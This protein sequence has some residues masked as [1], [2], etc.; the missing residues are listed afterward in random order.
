MINEEERTEII[1]VHSTVEKMI[2]N[3]EQIDVDAES[4]LRM[5]DDKSNLMLYEDLHKYNDLNDVLGK[6]GSCIFLY[7]THRFEGH[8]SCIFKDSDNPDRLIFFDSYGL[9]MDEEL[10]FSEHNRRLHEGDIVPH[11]TALVNKSMYRVISNTY[12]YQK[13]GS[14]NSECGS[15][16][17]CRIIFR[18]LS[19]IQYR[20]FLTKN[21]HHD[22]DFWTVALTLLFR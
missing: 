2:M 11:L 20:K 13:D 10:Q 7:Q 4:M 3:A 6:H 15:H 19:P 12:R 17:A 16:T 21:K 22:P 18:H 9:K 5:V 1:Q 8:W 14:R